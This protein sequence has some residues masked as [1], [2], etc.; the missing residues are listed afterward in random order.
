MCSGRSALGDATH[1]A[2]A[3]KVARNDVLYP[4]PCA[5]SYKMTSAK[6]LSN[7]PQG[8]I[9][10]VEPDP[11]RQLPDRICASLQHTRAHTERDRFC[12]EGVCALQ[13]IRPQIT[14]VVGGAAVLLATGGLPDSVPMRSDRSR[15]GMD[16]LQSGSVRCCTFQVE[17]ELS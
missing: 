7:S 1:S 6:R 4:F 10:G 13:R 14:V 5:Y 3:R 16:G 15:I 2:V 9:M 8:E 11:I 12:G 17:S